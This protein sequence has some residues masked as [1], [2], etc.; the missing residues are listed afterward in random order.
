MK[1]EKEQAQKRKTYR[2]VVKDLVRASLVDGGPDQTLGVPIL[3]GDVGVGKNHVAEQLAAELGWRL[4]LTVLEGLPW[5]ELGGVLV[6]P[7]RQGDRRRR[8]E[9]VTSYSRPPGWPWSED[10]QEPVLWVLDEIDKAEPEVLTL[11]AS[12]LT[13]RGVHGHR[14]QPGVRI[15]CLANEFDR[16]LPAFLVNR[17]LWINFPEPG[18]EAADTMQVLPMAGWLAEGLIN[19]KPARRP[20]R[21]VSTRTIAYAERWIT[22]RPDL[23]FSAD[24]QEVWARALFPDEAVQEVCR[25]LQTGPRSEAWRLALERASAGQL[26]ELLPR[27]M[28][29]RDREVRVHLPATLYQLMQAD[30]TGEKA[31][32]VLAVLMLGQ[33]LQRFVDNED[34]DE[35]ALERLAQKARE[36]YTELQ[37]Q[38]IQITYR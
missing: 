10:P 22:R 6:P 16:P 17:M 11:M 3:I 20:P 21:T 30:A 8:A 29:L 5:W 33:D 24:H 14:L 32:A 4:H 25:R 15:L 26:L 36:A 7:W 35:A 23:V 28:H 34:L 18:G 37:R 12:L 19:S 13:A 2:E 1:K 31:L 38:Q 9:L 27:I